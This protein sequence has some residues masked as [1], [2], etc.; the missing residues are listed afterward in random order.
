MKEVVVKHI[1][2]IDGRFR[3]A[4]IAGDGIPILILDIVQLINN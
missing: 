2:G 4:T 1:I 3:E